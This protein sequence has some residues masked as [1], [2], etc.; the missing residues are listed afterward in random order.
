MQHKLNEHIIKLKSDEYYVVQITDHDAQRLVCHNYGSREMIEEAGTVEEW[1]NK[2]INRAGVK[3]FTI[4]VRRRNGSGFKTKEIDPTV[5]NVP[6]HT[7]N[8]IPAP[9]PAAAPADAGQ[10]FGGGLNG[11]N[12]GLGYPGLGAAEVAFRAYDQPRLEEKAKRLESELEAAK[13]KIAELKEKL[14][15]QK[16]SDAKASGNQELITTLLGVLPGAIASFKGGAPAPG[17]N[18][19]QLSPVKEQLTQ[20]IHAQSDIVCGWLM[21]TMSGFQNE[22]FIAELK[23]LLQK[24]KLIN[25]NE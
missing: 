4:V 1:F 8:P 3:R 23:Q 22:A 12:I 17:L 15:E 16:F 9:M 2:N 11:F 21:A 25:E 7:E 18:A 20:I 10:P 24:Y 6:G 13:E 5:Y 19:P 14:L